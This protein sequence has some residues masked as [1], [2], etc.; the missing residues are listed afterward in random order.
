MFSFLRSLIRRFIALIKKL[1]GKNPAIKLNLKAGEP[2]EK[3]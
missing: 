2:Q 1:F 3:S